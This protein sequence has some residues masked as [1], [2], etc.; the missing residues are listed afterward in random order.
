METV[1]GPEIRILRALLHQREAH[2]REDLADGE[3]LDTLQGRDE[4]HV[5]L[6]DMQ[7]AKS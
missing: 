1:H 6:R 4:P 2:L 3:R 7:S 5:H